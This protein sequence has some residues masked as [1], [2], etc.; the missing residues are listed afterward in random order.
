MGSRVERRPWFRTY[1]KQ[2]ATAQGYLIKRLKN[3]QAG[4][5]Q[6]LIRDTSTPDE[7]F[8]PPAT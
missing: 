4:H 6:L 1:N 8:L 7:A 2:K 5:K 3:R